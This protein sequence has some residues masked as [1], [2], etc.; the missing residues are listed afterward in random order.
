MVGSSL[1]VVVFLVTIFATLIITRVATVILSLTGLSHE[2]A[3]FQARSAFTGTGF[4]TSEA[5]SVVNHPLRRRVIM[6]L[7][8][9]R[10][11]GV[12]TL[13]S[14]LLFS[15]VSDASDESRV[16]KLAVLLAGILILWLLSQSKQVEK[17]LNKLI[18]SGLRRWTDLD[19][20]DYANL[21]NLA[22]NYSVI[23]IQVQPN[24]WLAEKTLEN[25]QLLQ[26]GVMVLGIH[27]FSGSYQGVPSGKARIKPGD[28]LI[29]YG[30]KRAVLQLDIRRRGEEG[31]EE[32]RAAV[33]N[34]QRQSESFDDA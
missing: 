20:R 19:T 22:A 7:M 2:A 14:S 13:I 31:D 9:V 12:I 33:A 6:V 23:E 4:T 8:V 25:L 10:G 11:A 26:E 5:E 24:D 16:F 15:F 21:L 30:E 28:R 17:V 3:R 1:G 18:E 29:L 32:H 34:Q 27:R